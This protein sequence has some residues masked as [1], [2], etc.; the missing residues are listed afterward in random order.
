M[1]FTTIL[2]AAAS[3]TGFAAAQTAEQPSLV[4]PF[5]IVS[6]SENR[7]YNNLTLT[8]VHIGAGINIAQLSKS[9]AHLTPYYL[10]DTFWYNDS[11]Q[12]RL[13]WPVPGTDFVFNGGLNFNLSSNLAAL[14]ISVVDPLYTFGF[15]K[16][17]NLVIQ[18]LSSWQLC[19]FNTPYGD[20]QAVG[21][22]LGTSK[23]ETKDCL[24]I[25]LRKVK[26]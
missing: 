16:K 14:W 23:P 1:K 12:G 15:D 10:N 5:G 13:A 4:G 7:K 3:L 6:V 24:P 20:K 18:G 8:S 2:A 9:P 11:P 25:K 21:W 17:D 22:K 19:T 26:L